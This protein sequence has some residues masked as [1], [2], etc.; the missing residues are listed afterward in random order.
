MM[1][2][3]ATAAVHESVMFGW[4]ERNSGLCLE[5]LDTYH[6]LLAAPNIHDCLTALQAALINVLLFQA[7]AHCSTV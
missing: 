4:G 2:V 7:R 6:D 1:T 5:A 3:G